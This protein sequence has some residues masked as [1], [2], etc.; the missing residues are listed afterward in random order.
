MRPIR[1]EN[2]TVVEMDDIEPIACPCGATRRAFTD[3]SE[4][5]ASLHVVEIKADSEVHYHKKL[6][7]IYYILEGEGRMELDGAEYPVRPGC[8]VLIKRGCRHRAVGKLKVI[9]VAV[10]AID[11]ADEW[12][13]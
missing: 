5:I 8:A 2:F 7:E 12:F 3:D 1:T 13:D 9:V 11:P 10:P 4:R 6:T